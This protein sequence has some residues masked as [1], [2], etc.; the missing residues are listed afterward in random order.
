MLESVIDVAGRVGAAST[1]GAA[2]H[3]ERH[4]QLE[5]GPKRQLGG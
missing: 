2:L 5:L 1:A 4:E 3:V